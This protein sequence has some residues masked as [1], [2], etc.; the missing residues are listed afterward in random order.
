[1]KQTLF[2]SG[3]TVLTLI[4]AYPEERLK[5]QHLIIDL[6]ITTPDLGE[7]NADEL[8]NV[9]DYATLTS[10]IR[11]WAGKQTFILLENFSRALIQELAGISNAREIT[12]TV[13]K[14]AAASALDTF[15]I[16]LR[17]TWTA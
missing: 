4:G 10:T 12:L 8:S 3:L 15:E 11:E 2:I 1:M 14:P 17:T 6:E 9:T 16:G 5:Q 7:K 13:R